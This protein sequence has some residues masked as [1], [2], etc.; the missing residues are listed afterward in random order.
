MT[1]QLPPNYPLLTYHRD[2]WAMYGDINKPY[3]V[4][5]VRGLVQIIYEFSSIFPNEFV[6]TSM[7]A[8]PSDQPIV[9]DP[10]NNIY[11]NLRG[12]GNLSTVTIVTCSTSIIQSDFFFSII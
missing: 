12:H 2:E 9:A 10:T 6:M 3:R 7:V 5:F 8:T 1:N 4:R 11:F